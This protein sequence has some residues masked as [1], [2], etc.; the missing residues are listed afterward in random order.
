MDIFKS[1][2]AVFTDMTD[3]KS[4]LLKGVPEERKASVTR[5]LYE[6][7]D[8]REFKE[9]GDMRAVLRV[10]DQRSYTDLGYPDVLVKDLPPEATYIRPDFFGGLWPFYSLGLDQAPEEKPVT[11]K[12]YNVPLKNGHLTLK[13]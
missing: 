11:E 4:R 7:K 5:V 13:A 10:Y 1:I 6:G 2:K 9:L 12:V 3:P 8:F